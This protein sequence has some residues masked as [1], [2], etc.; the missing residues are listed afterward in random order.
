MTPAREEQQPLQETAPV[1]AMQGQG[2]LHSAQGAGDVSLDM[3]RFYR[4]HQLPVLSYY[5]TAKACAM[6]FASQHSSRAYLK[7]ATL[8]V[9]GQGR[10]S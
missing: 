6:V 5:G 7:H 9:V 2:T 1:A 8:P 3:Q 4:K 10:A